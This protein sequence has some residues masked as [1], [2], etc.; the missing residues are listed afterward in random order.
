MDFFKR[1]FYEFLI[2]GIII[3]LF[4]TN[5]QPHTYL[6]GW[7][8][9]QTDL[10]PLLGIKRAFFSLWQEYQSLGLL[11]GMGHAADLVR[12]TYIYLLSFV[13]PQSLLRYIFHF[14]MLLMGVWGMFKLLTLS[15]FDDVKRKF[16]FVGSLFYLFNFEVTQMMFFPFEPFSVFVGLLPLEIWIF[17]KVITQKA[18]RRDWILFIL[19]NL[20]A[21]P[22][23]V[24]QQL[25]VVYLMLL[26]LLTLGTFIT[27]KSK[28]LLQ[29]AFLALIL[30]LSLNSF[31]LMPQVYFL[32]TSGSVVKESKINQIATQDIVY[33]NKDKGNISDFLRFEGFFYDRVDQNQQP[34]FATWKNYRNLPPVSLAIYALSF[35]SLVGLSIKSKFRTGFALCLGLVGLTLLSNTPPFSVLN[36]LI[37]DNGFV[38]QIFR[39]PFTKFSIPFALMSAYFF[40]VTLSKIDNKL[41]IKK[42]NIHLSL[43]FILGLGLIIGTT[44]PSFNHQSISSEMQVNYPKPYLDLMS[45]FRSVDKNKRIGLLPEYTFWG[46]YHNR[47]GYD[48]SGFLWYGIEQPIISRTFDV[49]SMTSESYFWEL[50]SA[51]EAEDPKA[52]ENVLDKYNVDYLLFDTSLMPIVSSTKGIQYQSITALL[53]KTPSIKKIKTFG[54]LYLYQVSHK[55]PTTAFV[56]LYHTVPNIGPEISVTNNDTAYSQNGLYQTDPTKPYDLYYPFLDFMTQTK[57]VKKGW[58]ITELTNTWQISSSLPNMTDYILAPNIQDAAINLYSENLAVQY[59]LPVNS[60][61]S[62]NS[63]EISFPKVR[64]DAFIPGQAKPILC[65]P[66]IR[67]VVRSEIIADSSKV[68]ARNGAT[69][70]ISFEDLNLDQRYGYLVSVKSKNNIGQP[71]FFYILDRT[72]DQAYVED[73]LT[74]PDEY[75]VLGS[76]YIGGLGYSFT[77]QSTSLPSVPAINTLESLSVD[78]LPYDQLKTMKLI[79]KDSVHLLSNPASPKSV[80]KNAYYYYTIGLSPTANNSTLVLNQ[81]FHPGWSAYALSSHPSI[82]EQKLPF[83]F[84]DKIKN[85]VTV[86]NWANGWNIPPHS[87]DMQII[88]IFTPQYL[89]Y[90]G[91][92]LLALTIIGGIIYAVKSH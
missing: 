4:I 39:S 17:L 52:L 7:D 60:S 9:L 59:R 25:F 43:A 57:I 45:Y 85:H 30:I 91:L 65:G 71:F 87:Q 92:I 31:W 38:N 84:A 79:K 6:S 40:S 70:C 53:D 46:W 76:K 86:N 29:K 15:G 33:A 21:T 88:L 41:L 34:L 77:F 32:A 22:Q 10:N 48:G 24:T 47:W 62:S 1:H 89:E 51:L 26:G 36:D 64:L 12:A 83:I 44:I 23:G 2:L 35:L 11:A 73:R 56:G 8:N 5:Y 27:N 66:N 49:W 80:A 58:N 78:I 19:I 42:K 90:T 72:K 3:L 28:S 74:R 13:F 18:T 61:L 75:Y 16:A 20:M 63:L 82:L 69:G 67:G 14:S 55:S 81:S 68:I 50:K 37:R 54:F